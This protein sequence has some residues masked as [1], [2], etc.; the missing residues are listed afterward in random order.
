MGPVLCI[1]ILPTRAAL[2]V[3]LFAQEGSTEVFDCVCIFQ[4]K[5]GNLLRKSGNN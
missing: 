5:K 3:M 2:I 1:F 4:W